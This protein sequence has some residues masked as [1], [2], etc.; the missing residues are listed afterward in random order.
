MSKDTEL[1]SEDCK[2]EEEVNTQLPEATSEPTKI[3]NRKFKV[4][5]DL[6]INASDFDPERSL[7]PDILTPQ[8]KLF[9]ALLNNQEVLTRYLERR[10]IKELGIDTIDYTGQVSTQFAEALTENVEILE[11]V[12]ASLAEEDAYIF[13]IEQQQGKFDDH[14][15]ALSAVTLS[16]NI[17]INNL[18]IEQIN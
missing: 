2:S 18:M 16:F 4:L 12:I 17:K 14:S 3:L 8:Y 7:S 5:L 10:I 11:P 1:N 6:E 15:G 9:H 13:R